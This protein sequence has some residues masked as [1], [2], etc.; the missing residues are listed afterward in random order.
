MPP[1]RMLAALAALA[2]TLS[3]SPPAAAAEADLSWCERHYSTAGGALGTRDLPWELT[4]PRG[5]SY[6]P[7]LF[8]AE[9]IQNRQV[10]PTDLELDKTTSRGQLRYRI[11]HLIYPTLGNPNLYDAADPEDAL[12]VALRLSPETIAKLGPQRKMEGTDARL[13]EDPAQVAGALRLLLMPRSARAA[14][15]EAGPVQVGEASAGGARPILPSCVMIRPTKGMPDELAQRITAV[16]VFDQGAL[17]GAPPLL[18]DLRLELGDPHAEGFDTELAYNAVRIFDGLPGGRMVALNIA[19]SQASVSENL[20]GV[21]GQVS[22]RTL[23]ERRL[24]AFVEAVNESEDPDVQDAS[25][26]SFNGDLHNG[27]SPGTILPETVANTYRR[28]AEAI[29]TLLRE[30]PLPIFL[31]VGNHDGYASTGVVPEPIARVTLPQRW[32]GKLIARLKGWRTQWSALGRT[33]PLAKVVEKASPRDH[34]PSFD[35][36][37]YVNSYLPSISD[38]P[39]GR[40]VDIF[41]GVYSRWDGRDLQSWAGWRRIPDD[42]LN[43][44]LYDG[45]NQWRRSYG[46]LSFSHVWG[47]THFISL[48]TYDLRQHRRAGWGMYTANYGGGVSAAQAAWLNK[49]LGRSQTR[50]MEVVILAHHD[51][52][53]GHEGQDFPYYFEQVDYTGL[54]ASTLAYVKGEVVSPVLCE[55]VGGIPE[56]LLPAS[57]VTRCLHDGLQEWMRPDPDFDC[58]A[59][60]R[61]PAT[62]RCGPE[63]FDLSGDARKHPVFSG[64]QIIDQLARRASIR[65]LI[66]GHTHY[67]S[68]EVLQ[69][70]QE[71]VPSALI[72]EPEDALA[73]IEQPATTE[74]EEAL[75]ELE[76]VSP[77]RRGE[78][79]RGDLDE[80]V[81]EGRRA[82][83]M[84]DLSAAG[85]NFERQLKGHELVVLRMTTIADLTA[86]VV[87]GFAMSGYAVMRFDGDG[88]PGSL[89]S[90]RYFQWSPLAQ[91]FRELGHLQLDRQATWEAQGFEQHLER[92]RQRQ[93]P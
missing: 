7:D 93:L 58:A 10:I 12:M 13:L 74:A 41:T 61:D 21:P 8:Y 69:P 54:T 91:S 27:G 62:G 6:L 89:S 30:L 83:V 78:R 17:M 72:F 29:V 67:N 70:G 75:A 38:Q 36:G 79:R 65:T 1:T 57:L 19:D 22:F 42:E 31:T 77:L 71:L 87:D 5:E 64:F 84:L 48:N 52:R 88:G 28:E 26:I 43:V 44:A 2:I 60:D 66:L 34:W 59:A 47:G 15:E 25:F 37:A 56:A 18:Y 82:R 92:Q 49:Q 4:S 20:D 16:L 3:L 39:G 46:P 81:R 35:A 23:S 55:K 11:H 86:Q 24:A 33:W 76:I 40:P 51:P 80:R 45:F 73:Y 85:H 14:A 32:I 50:G 63:V 9:P 90:L 53:G 68:V